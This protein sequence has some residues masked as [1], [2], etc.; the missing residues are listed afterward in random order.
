MKLG[1]QAGDGE[2]LSYGNSVNPDCL[3]IREAAQMLG[4]AAQALSE[5]LAILAAASH[6]HEPVRQAQEQSDG[7][8]RAV[9]QVHEGRDIVEL[10]FEFRLRVRNSKSFMPGEADLAPC[11]TTSAR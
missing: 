8:K 4:H 1:D 3:L 6:L 7:Q 9:K 11:A 10:R 2:D 5:T